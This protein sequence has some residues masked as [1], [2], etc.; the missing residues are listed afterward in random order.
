MQATNHPCASISRCGSH[1]TSQTPF[2]HQQPKIKHNLRVRTNVCTRCFS[3]QPEGAS[4][5]SRRESL[6]LGSL[7]GLSVLIG[8]H[9]QGWFAPYY[10][11]VQA[12]SCASFPRDV[13]PLLQ[14]SPCSVSAAACAGRRAWNTEVTALNSARR[15]WN[16]TSLNAGCI[17]SLWKAK[18]EQRLNWSE[19][20]IG[21]NARGLMYVYSTVISHSSHLVATCTAGARSACLR[22]P[23]NWDPKRRTWHRQ[24]PGWKKWFAARALRG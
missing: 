5:S 3:Y 18:L 17:S 12:F 19:R 11:G 24:A 10:C 13:G 2:L 15:R 23:Y 14:F 8:E 16:C 1:C 7:A 6:S 20:F 22:S 4:T 21:Y 9:Q